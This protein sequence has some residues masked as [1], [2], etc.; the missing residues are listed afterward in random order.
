MDNNLKF[1][2][3][4][5]EEELENYK[6]IQNVED[7]ENIPTGTYIKYICKKSIFKKKGGFFK[8]IKNKSILEL[9]NNLIK[10]KWCIYIDKYYLFYRISEKE[11]L[12]NLL[13]KMIDSNFEILKI[14]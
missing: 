9:Y 7:L 5:Y 11:K 8:D 6:Y 14:N 10:K 12:K 1:I 3:N 2:L 13:Q 4:K